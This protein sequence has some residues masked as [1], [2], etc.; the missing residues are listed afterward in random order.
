MLVGVGEEKVAVRPRD[1]GVLL[2]PPRDWGLLS[3]PLRRGQPRG[4]PK[5]KGEWLS[6]SPPVSGPWQTRSRPQ[7]QPRPRA[8]GCL[9][10]RLPG[11][12]PPRPPLQ[13]STPR[14]SVPRSYPW[15]GHRHRYRLRQVV[16]RLRWTQSQTRRAARGPRRKATKAPQRRIGRA[17]AAPVA[18]TSTPAKGRT[19][20]PPRKESRCRRSLIALTKEKK[21][22]Q[23]GAE[24]SKEHRGGCRQSCLRGEGGG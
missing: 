5:R 3:T 16:L 9:Q 14:G 13:D 8:R 2:D 19:P 24:M 17:R 12:D 11:R 23:Q 7:L 18:R 6:L 1:D 10:P 21:K 4:R 22:K 15:G 20:T